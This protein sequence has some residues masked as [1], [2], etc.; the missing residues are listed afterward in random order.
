VPSVEIT[1]E[2]HEKL[3]LFV[4]LRYVFLVIKYKKQAYTW[5]ENEKLAQLAKE[6]LVLSGPPE[7]KLLPLK[8]IHSLWAICAYTHTMYFCSLEDDEL[9]VK[10]NSYFYMFKMAFLQYPET[11]QLHIDIA[12]AYY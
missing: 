3:E 9:A 6:C 2:N 11:F 10:A 5:E 7:Q 1:D 8:I 12:I 4:Y